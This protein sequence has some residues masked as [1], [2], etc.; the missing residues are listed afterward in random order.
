MIK[1]TMIFCEPCGFKKII[2]PDEELNLTEIPTCPV[3]IDI[4]K[5]DPL[6]NKAKTKPAKVRNK[7]YKCPKCGRGVAVK[8][9]Q[10]AYSSAFKK[11]DEEEEKARMALDKQKRIEDGKPIEKE[12]EFTG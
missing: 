11:I 3:P 4:P 12:P 8:E 1:R 10:A 6:T 5:L 2:E 7:K 9:L